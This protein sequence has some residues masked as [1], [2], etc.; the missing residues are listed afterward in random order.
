MYILPIVSTF[1]AAVVNAFS[2][3][4]GLRGSA[5][6]TIIN[7]AIAAI[8]SITI[9]YEVVY[10]NT[11]VS[12]DLFGTWF[13]AGSLKVQY[14]MLVD[15]YCAQMFLTV[16]L[17][18][19][20][21][22][23]YALAY[24]QADPHKPLFMS[25]LALFTC[26]MLVLVS[27]DNMIVML[28][29]FE[30][31]GICSYLLI[32]YYNHRLHAVKAA[33]QAI[34]VNRISDGILLFSIIYL[35]HYVGS[36]EY[37]IISLHDA[38][39]TSNLIGYTILI[40]TIAKSAQIPMHVWLPNAMEGPTPVSALIHAA[41]LVTAGVYLMVRLNTFIRTPALILGSITAISAAIYAL[42][43]QD[44]KRV[45]AFSTCSQLGFMVTAIGFG[46]FGIEASIGHLLTHASFK[47][48]LF[49]S[50]GLLIMGANNHQH[51]GRY[52][53]IDSLQSSNLTMTII[54]IGTLAIIGLPETSGFYSKELILNIAYSCIKPLSGYAHI[55][56][57]LTALLTCIYSLKLYILVYLGNYNGYIS[58]RTS[59]HVSLPVSI[60]LTL[61]VVDILLKTWTGSNVLNGILLF[62]PWLTKSIPM[63]LIIAGFLTAST[64]VTH[65]HAWFARFCGTKFGVEQLYNA[66][67]VKA[68]LDLGRISWYVGDKGLYYVHQQ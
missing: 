27:A 23:L 44:L 60:A 5:V 47:A 62:I 6:I 2:R 19:C 18:S 7:M 22:Q 20:A 16:S 25:Y 29:G 40:G 39:S 13:E 24:M 17:V 3:S 67:A 61:L 10:A 33:Q 48:A 50:A 21:V 68:T 57:L 38:S 63:G 28:I 46:E 59:K 42:S 52:G 8:S 53:S 37:D 66:Y 4:I 56:L 9:W 51:L 1:I 54:L 43:Q 12:I 55:V 35:N 49:M 31:I 36:V 41:T 65:K 45:I 32:G 34:L 15:S 64:F 58:N 26:C 30:G 11:A 14:R